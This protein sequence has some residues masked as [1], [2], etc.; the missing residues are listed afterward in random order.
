MFRQ[1]FKEYFDKK[2][3]PY[4]GRNLI[5]RMKALECF[6]RSLSSNQTTTNGNTD[7]KQYQHAVDYLKS[8]KDGSKNSPTICQT[9]SLQ[10]W[11]VSS[12][13]IVFAFQKVRQVSYDEQQ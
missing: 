13:Y 6:P 9:L 5:E 7:T 8:L 3:Q 12:L 1:T 11:E 4:H 2:S 10:E